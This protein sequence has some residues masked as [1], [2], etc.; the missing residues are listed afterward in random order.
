MAFFSSSFLSHGTLLYLTDV[1][2]VSV[3]GTRTSARLEKKE[4]E[5]IIIMI[6]NEKNNISPKFVL[7]DLITLFCDILKS[8]DIQEKVR[9]SVVVFLPTNQYKLSK[10]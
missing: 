3:R 8:N 10:L 2:V 1:F 7:G 9:G 4:K 5:I 6:S